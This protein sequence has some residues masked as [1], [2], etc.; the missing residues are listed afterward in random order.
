MRLTRGILLATMLAAAALGGC[1]KA[2]VKEPAKLVEI[3]KP[4]VRPNEVWSRRAGNGSESSH[5]LD[6]SFL[7]ATPFYSG[8]RLQLE[9][10]A[11]YTASIDGSVRAIDPKSGNPIWVAETKARVIAGPTVAG[12]K[13][14]VGTLDGEAI[15]LQR[16]SGKL[17]WRSKFS[18]E[19]GAAPVA[20][21]N[22]VIVR[23]ID[24]REFGL[25]TEDGSGLWS[26]D[27]GVPN[28]TLRGMSEPL[29]L[30]NRVY[31]GMDNGK[32]AALNLADGQ[33]AWEQTISAP[34]GRSELDRLTDIDADLLAGDD[35]I[36]VVSYGNDIA[37]VDPAGGDSRWRRSIKSYTNMAT[38]GKK[39]Y[40]GDDESLIWALDATSGAALWKQD[41][42]KYR[43][44]SPPAVFGN[45]IVVG[46]YKGYLHWFEQGE[47]RLVARTRVGSDPIETA[48]VSDGT[49]LYVIDTTGHLVAYEASP[50][51]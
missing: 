25:S 39:V 48:P 32:L 20:S 44:L 3:K 21:G 18:S 43:R 24:G 28:L 40:V 29:I 51:K 33:L 37:L 30:G 7:F 42:L 49:R 10:D 36:F 15:A 1:S 41:I 11:L 6:G 35:G 4:E 8:L 23:T 13:V 9:A 17:L 27:R 31:T 47:G 14:Y 38:D 45:Y 22:V 46:D 34:T 19:V 50:A 5:V 2:K 16:A 12:D 26:F